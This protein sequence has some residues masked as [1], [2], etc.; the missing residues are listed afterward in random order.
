[1]KAF[2]VNGLMV[3]ISLNSFAQKPPDGAVHQ[4]S[5]SFL[6]Q[7]PPGDHWVQARCDVVTIEKGVANDGIIEIDFLEVI[8]EDLTTGEIVSLAREDYSVDGYRPSI[9]EAGLYRRE[10]WFVDDDKPAEL[11]N[12]IQ[13]GGSLII[14]VG[15]QPDSISHFWTK[16]TKNADNTRH[17]VVIRFRISGE[18]GLQVGLDYS[19]TPDCNI[20]N[21]T[22]AFVSQWY[23]DTDGRFIEDTIPDYTLEK[24]GREHYGVYTDGTFFISKQ[25]VDRIEGTSVELVTE[26]NDWIHEEMILINDK[27]QYNINKTLKGLIRYCFRVD[28]LDS[29]YIPDAVS[30]HLIFLNEDVVDNLNQ[31]G[32]DFLTEA[33]VPLSGTI[34][35]VRADLHLSLSPDSVYLYIRSPHQIRRIYIVDMAGRISYDNR[36]NN[37]GEVLI[38]GLS[39]GTYIVYIETDKGMFAEKFVK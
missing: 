25:L 15:E 32:Y 6:T 31:N 33:M 18:I 22:E 39:A 36:D 12:S 28:D 8:Q 17:R 27:F 2:Y 37:S 19:P 11:I 13:R 21:H 24:L 4:S 7:A 9:Y 14:K 34:S 29:N 38:A 1:M 23:Y 35:T 5:R 26:E 16:C 30:N 3:L 20:N 10:P